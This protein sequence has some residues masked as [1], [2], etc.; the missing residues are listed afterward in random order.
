ML[1]TQGLLLLAHLIRNG[2]GRVVDS[3]RDHVYDLRQLERFEY[4]DIK[5]KD[6]GSNSKGAKSMNKGQSCA[7]AV[8]EAQS[9]APVREPPERRYLCHLS[10]LL[11]LGSLTTA[12]S[13]CLFISV[14]IGFCL[15][16]FLSLVCI[17]LRRSTCFHVSV[18]LNMCLSV[19]V[20][21]HLCLS[22]SIG[23]H[24]A[25]SVFSLYVY[26]LYPRLSRSASSVVRHKA[27]EIC[28]LLSDEVRLKEERRTAKKN[29]NKYK[30]I[31]NRAFAEVRRRKEQR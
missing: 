29:R 30:G 9:R 14:S 27:K 5:G 4:I 2:S 8:A 22:V 23:Y 18:C 28:D 13:L 21:L 6:E 24:L 16:L 20:C 10:C 3:A 19:S 11:R 26:H 25:A 12:I 15:S 17:S 7:T 1:S 31:G